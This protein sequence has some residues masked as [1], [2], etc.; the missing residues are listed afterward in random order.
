MVAMLCVAMR[1][2][3]QQ[4]TTKPVISAPVP[5]ETP[6]PAANATSIPALVAAPTDTARYILSPE[7]TVQVTVFK[8]PSFSGSVPI[9]PDGM[10]SLSLVG[11]IPAAGM[12]PMQ[13]GA[14]IATRL[15]KFI[16]DPNVTVTVTGV[17]PKQ[18]YLLGEVAHIGPVGLTPEMSV[19]QVI[20]AAGGLSPYAK[21]KSIYILR[22]QP[23]HQK[24]I[25]FN[26]KKA[27]KEGNEQGVSLLPGDT[28][29]I[30]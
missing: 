6:A 4:G 8:E 1:V 3:A 20:A 22:G 23:G 12:T 27:L 16:N 30:P 14:D 24:K 7:D 5:A 29:V 13:L 25:P 15:K 10:I 19:L 28:I 2:N 17:K 21:S 18:V 9:R 11:D 26:Y